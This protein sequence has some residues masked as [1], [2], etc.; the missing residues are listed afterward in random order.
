MVVKDKLYSISSIGLSTSGQW[1]VNYTGDV[2]E[3]GG[4]EFKAGQVF[5]EFLPDALNFLSEQALQHEIKYRELIK[6]RIKSEVNINDPANALK[7]SKMIKEF[8]NRHTC[9]HPDCKGSKE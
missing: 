2:P 5:F 9:E 8:N 6:K 3:Q 4:I 7:V 1:F